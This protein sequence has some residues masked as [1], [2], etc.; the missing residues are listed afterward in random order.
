MISTVIVVVRYTRPDCI[1]YDA[2][3]GKKSS[4]DDD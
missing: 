2:V 4:Y 3:M 1:V